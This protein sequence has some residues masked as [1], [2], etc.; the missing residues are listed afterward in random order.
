MARDAFREVREIERMLFVI[1]LLSCRKIGAPFRL[2]G[3][4]HMARGFE[5]RDLI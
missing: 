1:Y 2:R 4:E 5:N 3:R